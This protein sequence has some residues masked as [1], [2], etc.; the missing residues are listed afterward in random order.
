MTTENAI[1]NEPMRAIN[2]KLCFVAAPDFVEMKGLAV[3][4]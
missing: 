2:R 1:G 4:S 3:W